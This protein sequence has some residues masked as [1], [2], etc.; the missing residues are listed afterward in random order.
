MKNSNVKF[1]SILVIVYLVSAAWVIAGTLSENS[2]ISQSSKYF[3]DS[4]TGR[5]INKEVLQKIINQYQNLSEDQKTALKEKMAKMTA[6]R[7]KAIEAV[8]KQIR[9]YRLQ[10]VKL[11][12]A[13]S[14][15]QR[16]NQLQ[17]LQLLALKGNAPETAKK[18]AQLISKY[19]N[20]E[21]NKSFKDNSINVQ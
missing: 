11:Q 6:E 15:Q 3:V 20:T 10:K 17:A 18:I 8:S 4:A 13:T 9:E 12:N 5:Q 14:Q 1:I 19:E 16:L 21:E 2:E 7:Q